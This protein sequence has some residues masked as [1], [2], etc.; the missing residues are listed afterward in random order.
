LLQ[1]IPASIEKIS[2]IYESA[3][4]G[5]ESENFFYN[6]IVKLRTFYGVEPLFLE[7]KKIEFLMGRKRSTV[8]SDRP[9]DLDIILYEDT[10]FKSSLIEVPHPKAWERA[11]VLLPLLDLEE[12]LKDPISKKSLKEIFEERKNILKEQKLYRLSLSFT[13]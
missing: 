7:L 10:S 11:F 5:Y 2:P 6:L 12:D 3:P 1:K 9:M 4:V 13:L 8:V